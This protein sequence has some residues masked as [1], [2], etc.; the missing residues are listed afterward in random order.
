MT[1]VINM[2]KKVYYHKY[3]YEV[4]NTEMNVMCTIS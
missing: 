2:E 4:L 1:Y 3:A